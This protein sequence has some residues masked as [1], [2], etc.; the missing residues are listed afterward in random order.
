MSIDIKYKKYIKLIIIRPKND[1]YIKLQK[2]NMSLIQ[3]LKQE[4]K[5]IKYFLT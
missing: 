5:I 2:L 3:L 1:K 4:F